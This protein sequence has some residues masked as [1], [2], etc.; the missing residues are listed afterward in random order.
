MVSRYEWGPWDTQSGRKTRA[1]Q[2]GDTGFVVHLSAIVETSA[3]SSLSH[4]S[5]CVA[6]GVQ[7]KHGFCENIPVTVVFRLEMLCRILKSPIF[8]V[9]K[10]VL[11]LIFLLCWLASPAEDCFKH[12]SPAWGCMT[13]WDAFSCCLCT[14]QCE[15]C[16]TYS[17]G[18]Q[19]SVFSQGEGWWGL[20]SPQPTH[21][22]Q[23]TSFPF[24][25]IHTFVAK[26][27]NLGLCL[28]PKAWIDFRD[29]EARP[30]DFKK[31]RVM[32]TK[33]DDALD[34]EGDPLLTGLLQLIQTHLCRCLLFCSCNKYY[35]CF[36]E[37]FFW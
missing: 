21:I 37:R 31:A 25:C 15:L 22:S 17:C 29:S 12:V 33:A 9:F 27:K 6:S 5:C 3:I 7:G 19:L 30:Y 28:R 32:L 11:G 14:W 2:C 18:A 10:S 16:M 36:S 23:A 8:L 4:F 34:S 13:L 26:E 24:H 20:K 35:L 1:Q